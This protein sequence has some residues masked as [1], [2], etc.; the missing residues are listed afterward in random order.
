[1]IDYYLKRTWRG[2]KA[3]CIKYR[4][5]LRMQRWP[6][7]EEGTGNLDRLRQNMERLLFRSNKRSK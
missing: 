1:M 5:S 4:R 7:T 2:V 3:F 6:V